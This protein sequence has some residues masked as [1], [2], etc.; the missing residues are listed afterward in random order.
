MG[1]DTPEEGQRARCPR[2]APLARR[3][4]QRMAELVEAGVTMERRG[5]DR[6]G[7][8]IAVVRDAQGRDV[9]ALLIGEELAAP[10]RGRGL[11]RDWCKV[12]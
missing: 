10:Y 2:E 4:T 7:R 3:A 9:A 11:R 5:P 12:P 1:L 8:T 6:Y